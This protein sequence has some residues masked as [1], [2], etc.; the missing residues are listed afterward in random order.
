MGSRF[1]RLLRIAP[2]TIVYVTIG[3]VL[4]L[5][6]T[7]PD[8]L[9][10]SLGVDPT[11][12]GNVLLLSCLFGAMLAFLAAAHKLFKALLCAG[13]DFVAWRKR[14]EPDKG[15]AEAGV[16]MVEFTLIAPTVW[17]IMAM[18][19]QLALIAEASLVVRYAAFTAARAATVRME[20]DSIPYLEEEV[21][22]DPDKVDQSAKLVL[23]SLSP[24]TPGTD[25][26][27]AHKMRNV[28]AAQNGVWGDKNFY[29][30]YQYADAATTVHTTTEDPPFEIMGF[31]LPLPFGDIFSPKLVKCDVTYIY[32]T[33]IPGITLIPGATVNAP[34]GQKGFPINQAVKMQGTGARQTNQ[35]TSLNP[36]AGS[37][38]P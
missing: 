9:A 33:K 25:N 4:V 13:R 12:A 21:S 26:D 6:A 34:G 3:V 31:S 8:K 5:L 22:I 16:V 24:K 17:W 35:L 14:N 18:V 10:A 23:C 27:S 37:P 11:Q 36:L 32:M 20:R 29:Q 15:F 7:R 19:V 30:R 2:A 28:F 38:F 1:Q